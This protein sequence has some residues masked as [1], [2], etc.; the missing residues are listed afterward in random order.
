MGCNT[1]LAHPRRARAPEIMRNPRWQGFAGRCENAPIEPLLG[2]RPPA[3][4]PLPH[5]ENQFAI[6]A[7]RLSLEYGACCARQR[8][9]MHSAVLGSLGWQHNPIV[10]DFRP[11]QTSDLGC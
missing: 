8:Q 6:V 11:P 4:G 2:F 1:E 7:L 3:E 10:K 9:H 5:S